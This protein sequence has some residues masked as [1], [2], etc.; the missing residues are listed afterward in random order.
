MLGMRSPFHP[1]GRREY[2]VEA[3]APDISDLAHMYQEIVAIEWVPGVV[4][5]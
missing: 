5:Y 4:L 2:K 3:P 1:S